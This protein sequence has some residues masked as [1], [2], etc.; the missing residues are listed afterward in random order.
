MQGKL[1]T[2][3]LAEAD[4][5][6]MMRMFANIRNKVNTETD[7]I[8]SNNNH[9]YR[10]GH[11]LEDAILDKGLVFDNNLVTQHHNIHEMTYL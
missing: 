6:S 1:R 7:E 2:T 8:F 3:Q 10:T 11:S 5:Q 4:L 9:E